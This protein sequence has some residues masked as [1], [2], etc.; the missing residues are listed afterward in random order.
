MHPHRQ[1]QTSA[2]AQ[3]FVAWSHF[4]V[5]AYVVANINN[6]QLIIIIDLFNKISEVYHQGLK[7]ETAI[8]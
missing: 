7:V 4:D 6:H 8:K 1:G 2:G 5:I 3:P